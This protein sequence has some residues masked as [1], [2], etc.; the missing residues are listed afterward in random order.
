MV[1]ILPLGSGFV[2]PE[3]F[4]DPTDPDPKHWRKQIKYNINLHR[5]NT[6]PGGL[7]IKVV[8]FQKKVLL[9]RIGFQNEK[10]CT[11]SF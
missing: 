9:S 11:F 1:D 3:I 10:L 2:D 5:R 4:A 8:T 7:L 6:F